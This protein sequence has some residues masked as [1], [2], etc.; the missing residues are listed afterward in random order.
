LFLVD[1]LQSS[2]CVI[3]RNG[4]YDSAARGDIAVTRNLGITGSKQ[5][6]L[7]FHVNNEDSRPMLTARRHYINEER[8]V[9][10]GI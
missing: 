4:S 1:T 6:I 3:L 8:D 9:P 5:A 2:F 10:R 7:L